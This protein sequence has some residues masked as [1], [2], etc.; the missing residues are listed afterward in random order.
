MWVLRSFR[1]PSDNC[2]QSARVGVR[3]SGST[4][5]ASRIAASGIPT[6]CEARMN[7]TLRRVSREK[8]RWLPVVRRLLIRPW[9]S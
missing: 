9:R 5:S 8:R 2:A 3:P 1:Q 7:A 4:A 6:R